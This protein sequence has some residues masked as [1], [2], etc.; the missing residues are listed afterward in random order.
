MVASPMYDCILDADG[1]DQ[2]L[3]CLEEAKVE[4]IGPCIDQRDYTTS[5]SHRGKL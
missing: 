1:G 3:M 5:E 4:K 2:F